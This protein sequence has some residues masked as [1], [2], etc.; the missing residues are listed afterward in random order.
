MKIARVRAP[1][2]RCARAISDSTPPSPLL[3][4][5]MTKMTYFTVT[6]RNSAHKASETT[7][8]TAGAPI[9]SLAACP[10]AAWKA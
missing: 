2:A 9:G 5:R 10:M 3:S 6:T 1:M 8:T 7:P 4:A